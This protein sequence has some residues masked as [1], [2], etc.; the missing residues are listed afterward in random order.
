MEGSFHWYILIKT[1]AIMEEKT[2]VVER[3]PMTE[4]EFKKYMESFHDL[5][6]GLHLYTFE[7]VKRFR[8]VRRAFRRGHISPYGEIYPK[9]P[10]SN[11]KPTR[12]RAMN[13]LKKKIYGE[14]KSQRKSA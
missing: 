7:A 4:E 8:S 5:G 12:G 11:R 6:G 2:N 1:L 10:F 13:E 14:L 9:R 3:A